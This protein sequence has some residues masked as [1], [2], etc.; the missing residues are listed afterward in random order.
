MVGPIAGAKV[1]ESANNAR[2]IGCLACGS[3]VMMMREGD[4]DQHAAG[5]T[6]HGAQHDHLRRFCAK[7]QATEKSRNSAALTS[8]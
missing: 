5:E 6:L 4:R 3:S 7:A 2:P 1:A 8:R